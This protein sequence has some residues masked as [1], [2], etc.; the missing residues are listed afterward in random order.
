[1]VEG[2]NASKVHLGDKNLFDCATCHKKFETRWELDRHAGQCRQP[3][4]K[5]FKLTVNGEHHCGICNLSFATMSKI[6]KHLFIDHTDIET[7]AAY[8]RGIEEL[9]QP[10]WMQRLRKVVYSAI[11]KGKFDKLV[12]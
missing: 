10:S 1:M 3:D 11:E 9:I 2:F 5:Y 12:G 6:K 8:Q 7:R 4:A